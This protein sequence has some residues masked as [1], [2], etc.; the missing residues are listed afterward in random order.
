MEGNGHDTVRAST[1][2][3]DHVTK[4]YRKGGGVD[5]L[6]LSVGPGEVFGF[7]GPNGAGKTTTIRLILD[8]IRPTRGTISIFGL[9]SRS[10]SVAIRRRIGYIPGDV[11]LYDRLTPREILSHFAHLRGGLAWSAINAQAE[12]L[13]L[14]MDRQI[15]TLSKGNR[16][17]VGLVAALMGDPELLLLDEPTS[18]LDPLVQQQVHEALRRAVREGRTV[19][20]SSHILSEVGQVADRV[21][22]IRE[23][24]LIA[25]ERVADLQQRPVHLVDATF[26]SVPDAAPFEALPG[27]GACKI[28]GHALH[29]EVSGSLN[30]VVATLAAAELTDLSIREPSLEELFLS[31]YEQPR[32]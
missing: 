5:D 19:F 4:H 11:A 12:E 3:L 15:R 23:G 16:Q 28:D 10:E 29:F 17:K 32:V 2:F 7:L 6:T 13:E 25:V 21:G 31:F 22:L 1:V 20:L 18:G 27:V 24:R 30:P 8:L 26:R 14:E 9:D